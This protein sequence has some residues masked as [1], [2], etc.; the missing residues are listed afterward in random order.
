M[1]LKVTRGFSH[2]CLLLSGERQSPSL[3]HDEPWGEFN[4]AGTETTSEPGWKCRLLCACVH[5]SEVW[6][7]VWA[8]RQVC[9]AKSG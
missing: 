5:N 1:G 6:G 2:V 8:L 4:L 9:E 7:Q 3:E